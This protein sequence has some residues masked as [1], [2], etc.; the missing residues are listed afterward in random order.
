MTE[1]MGTTPAAGKKLPNFELPD[2]NGRP[3]NLA[4]EA[5]EGPLVLVFYRGDW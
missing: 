2:E 4:R 1:R 3:F 5:A